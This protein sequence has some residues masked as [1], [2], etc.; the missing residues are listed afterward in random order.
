VALPPNIDAKN[1]PNEV[2][3]QGCTPDG[4]VEENVT[5]GTVVSAVAVHDNRHCVFH[6]ALS[7][8]HDDAHLVDLCDPKSYQDHSG[9]LLHGYKLGEIAE[10]EQHSVV[11]VRRAAH[12]AKV[13]REI[14]SGEMWKEMVCEVDGANIPDDDVHEDRQVSAG[15]AQ[16][17]AGADCD[18]LK[19]HGLDHRGLALD[20]DPLPSSVPK[21]FEAACGDSRQE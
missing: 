21:V 15:V 11:Q 2:K 13:G 5:G 10:K 12:T 1:A 14:G 20:N 6:D 8:T 7:P 16:V 18:E 4:Q 19:A 9:D 17:G 3:V